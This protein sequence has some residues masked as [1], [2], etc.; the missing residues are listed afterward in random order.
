MATTPEGKIKAKVKKLLNRHKVYS[1]MPVQNGMG[2]PTLDF[3]C[4]F[5]GAYLAIETK[6]PG[7]KP[8]PRQQKTMG[9]IRAAE[10]LA[11]V[12]SC[13]DDIEKLDQLLTGLAALK[14]HQ[15]QRSI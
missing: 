12:V 6:A 10:G 2:S 15:N 5:L 1:H 3:V 8:T 9:Q 7:K 4:C 11:L 14:A 13:D